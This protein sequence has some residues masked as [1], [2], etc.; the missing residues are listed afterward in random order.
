MFADLLF[1][2]VPK[3]P[4]GKVRRH[5]SDERLKPP[6]PMPTNAKAF[7]R[8]RAALMRLVNQLEDVSIPTICNELGWTQQT[9]RRYLK[10][11]VEDGELIS[12]T[13]KHVVWYRRPEEC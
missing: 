8:R 7:D 6:E 11:L 13:F 9:A 10:G 3:L 1:C 2:R 12:E 5:Y 4:K